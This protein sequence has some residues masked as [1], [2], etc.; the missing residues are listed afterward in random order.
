MASTKLDRELLLT[1]LA[2]HVQQTEGMW[3]SWKHQKSLLS[4]LPKDYKKMVKGFYSNGYYL[5]GGEQYEKFVE[6]FEQVIGIVSVDFQLWDAIPRDQFVRA[7]HKAFVGQQDEMLLISRAVAFV[8][9][10]EG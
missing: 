4:R 6:R 5:P 2:L 8:D 7:L 3:S 10:F 1:A 9:A